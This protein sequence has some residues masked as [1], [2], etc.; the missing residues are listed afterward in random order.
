M[1]NGL[2][3][4]PFLAL[5]ILI[6]LITAC[7]GPR[8]NMTPQ[9]E[10]EMIF[11]EA[12]R[13]QDADLYNEASAQLQEFLAKYPESNNADNAKLKIA[14][15]H[16]Y[17]GQYD[18][19]IEVYNEIIKQFPNG[20]SADWAMLGIGDSYF[21]M[22]KNHKAIE[23]YEKIIDKYPRFNKEVTLDAQERINAVSDIEENIRII[24]DGDSGSNI[25]DNAQYDIANIFFTVFNDNKRAIEEFQVV[26]DRWPKSELADDAMWKIGESYWAIARKKLPSRVFSDEK[27]AY[28]ELIEIFDRYP[29]LAKLEMF[30]LDVHWPAGKRGDSYELAYAQTRRIVN[31][32]PDIKKKQTYDFLPE[33]Y[34]KAF[35]TWQDVIFAYSYSDT[36]AYAREKI[37]LAYVDLGNLYY[38][39]GM[40][41]FG[42][43]LYR[44]SVTAKTTPEGHLGMARYYANITSTSGLPWA[45][46][47]AF[48]H[49]KKAE[50]LTPPDSPTANE[51]AWAKEWMNYKMRIE[52]LENWPEY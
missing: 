25:K 29:Q 18:L 36:A 33:N 27:K 1:T 16:Y 52:S 45:Y 15:G 30:H 42:S 34:K 32:Y 19:A 26:L 50:E 51:V 24:R 38:N 8:V 2:K 44:E 13:L 49:I 11:A 28:I 23:A 22:N 6:T 43:L 20:D 21:A 39:M 12:N 47:R 10:A 41:H 14:D 9:Q 5:I 3:F 31:K 17:Q 48:F 7:A 37:A 4:L 40:K 35:K 46:R